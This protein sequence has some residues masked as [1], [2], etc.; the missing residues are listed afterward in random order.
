MKKK[1]EKWW[2]GLDESEKIGV[3]EGI[4][5]NEVGLI[6][7]DELWGRTDRKDK[8]EAYKDMHD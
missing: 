8:L 7:S 6:D 3:I 4:Y 5:P 1:I 2:N